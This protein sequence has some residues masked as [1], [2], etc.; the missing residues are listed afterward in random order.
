MALDVVS[1]GII[2]IIFKNLFVRNIFSYFFIYFFTNLLLW[3]LQLFGNNFSKME[4]NIYYEDIDVFW[5][6]TY[7]QFDPLNFWNGNYNIYL[8]K[9]W[10]SG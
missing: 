3:N 6:K 2:I 10:L 4:E 1:S 9:M 8:T 7:V 5:E